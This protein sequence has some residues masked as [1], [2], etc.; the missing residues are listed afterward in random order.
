VSVD[1]IQMMKVMKPMMRNNKVDDDS[2]GNDDDDDEVVSHTFGERVQ[3]HHE[4]DKEHF[5]CTSSCENMK[6]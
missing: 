5:P 3:G 2:D 1:V 4:D 6:R